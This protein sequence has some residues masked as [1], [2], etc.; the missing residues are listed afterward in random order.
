MP[1][2]AV[3]EETP[4]AE[5]STP[6]SLSD[7]GAPNSGPATPDRGPMFVTI[8]IVAAFVLLIV[9]GAIVVLAN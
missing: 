4:P 2:G 8:G 7:Q 1:D 9:I 5:G 6:Q 3:P